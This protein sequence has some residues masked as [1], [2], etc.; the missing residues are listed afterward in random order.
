M[1]L[2]TLVILSLPLQRLIRSSLS[3]E[4]LSTI[5]NK[6]DLA[7]VS[8]FSKNE[9]FIKSVACSPIKHFDAP[10]SGSSSKF[11]KVITYAASFFRVRGY[12]FRH[13]KK[14]PYY[15]ANRYVNFNSTN[16]HYQFKFL[17]RFFLDLIVWLGYWD[18]T[19][20]FLDNLYGN[21]RYSCK[22]LIDFANKYDEVILIQSASWGFQDAALAYYARKKNW[23]TIFLPYTTD[24]LLCNGHL[25]ARYNVVCP[26]GKL[27]TS[28]A[29]D[30]HRITSDR[31]I[32]IPSCH[33]NS[34]SKQSRTQNLKS[35]NYLDKK[36]ILYA[37]ISAN[38]F[39]E[40]YEVEVVNYLADLMQS[41]FADKWTIIYR[42]VIDSRDALLRLNKG[43]KKSSNIIIEL[44]SP[45]SIG[46]DKFEKSN[47]Q[48]EQQKLIERLQEVDI[49]I[50]SLS[51][52]MALEAAILN[53]PVISYAPI[54]KDFLAKRSSG[55]M[56]HNNQMID[57]MS[58]PIAFDFDQLKELFLTISSN[59]EYSQEIAR[60]IL[61]DWYD[62]T[63]LDYPHLFEK[64]IFTQGRG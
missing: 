2:N 48:L 27:E 46:L 41:I 21:I 39:P 3:D 59:K 15:W 9:D 12:W 40:S 30:F 32:E 8:P 64:A 60:K 49:L 53:I 16:S 10:I 45:A 57:L 23:R 18:F 52:S 20:R 36:I 37:G 34:L 7:I 43:L 5:L 4:L 22:E 28:W 44:P 62:P 56:F 61:K 54:S 58:V 51:T 24:Q 14:I 17:S 13:R 11:L 55:L 35:E 6:S 63:N 26:Q 33:L 47:N 1:H 25:Y 31:I 38:Y 29:I 50:M 42:P 19:W